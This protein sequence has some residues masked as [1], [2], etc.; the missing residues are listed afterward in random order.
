MSDMVTESG[1]MIADY[2]GICCV[3]RSVFP[4]NNLSCNCVMSSKRTL[5]L[6]VSTSDR[7]KCVVWGLV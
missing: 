3:I 4:V 7:A 1:H 5:S 6:V 2:A